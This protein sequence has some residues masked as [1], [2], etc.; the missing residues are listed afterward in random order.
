MSSAIEATGKDNL[1]QNNAVSKG[2]RGAIICAAKHG[3]TQGN[4]IWKDDE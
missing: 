3:K 1:I 2:T 4:T